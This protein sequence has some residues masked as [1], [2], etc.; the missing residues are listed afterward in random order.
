MV[1]TIVKREMLEYLK[2]AKFLIGLGITVILVTLSTVINIDDLKQRQQDYLNAQQEMKGDRFYVQV[3]RAPQVL[4]TL[5]QGKD[6]KLGNSLQMTYFGLPMR[7]SGYMGQYTSEHHRY[8]AGFAAVDFAFV[9]RV[10][11]S[12]MVIFLAYN[13]VS[14]EKF[15][16][17][18]KLAL[19]NRLPRDQLLLGKFAG[20]LIVVV[21]SLLISAILAFL[22]MLLHPA[23]SFKGSD[24]TRLLL[25]LGVSAVYLVCFYTLSL[26]ISVMV[27]RPSI[28]LMILLQLWIFLVIV[29]PN[30][31]VIFAENI[32]NLPDEKEIGQRKVAAFQPYEEESRKIREAFSSAIRS[33]GSPSAEVGLRNTEL[34]IIRAEM[35]YQ[36]DKEFSNR[37]TN[38]MKLAQTVSILSPA[39]VYDQVMNR[40]ARTGMDE[41]ERFMEG[42][43]RHWQRHIERSKL[44]YKDREAYVKAQLPDFTY[45]SESTSRSFVGTLAQWVILFVFGLVFFALAYTAFLKKDVR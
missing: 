38:Q 44:L 29:Y 9:V 5:V 4:G 39:V 33:G 27:N 37:L 18:L 12:L 7:T 3:Y 40:L 30:M 16:G 17:T 22:I 25:M 26:F 13:A 32:Y 1:W 34:T 41:F 36:V 14:E 45:S 8:L 19:A 21:G 28:A 24:W 6:R 20:G 35:D 23:I 2:S 11:L 15:H 31:G 42:I 10:V 43:Y